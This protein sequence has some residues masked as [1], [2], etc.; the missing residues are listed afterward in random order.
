MSEKEKKNEIE[1]TETQVSEI[2]KNT[3]PE[4]TKSEVKSESIVAA[5]TVN[6]EK[7]EDVIV[8]TEEVVEE[9]SEVTIEAVSTEDN[10]KSKRSKRSKE[11]GKGRDCCRRRKRLYSF[12]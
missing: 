1:I 6:E 8:D 3:T 10:K 11:G 2:S 5:E 9:K 7:T 4:N 12:I